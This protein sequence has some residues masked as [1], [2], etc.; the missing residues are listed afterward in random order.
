[1]FTDDDEQRREAL[2]E[3]LDENERAA[4]AEVVAAEDLIS[5]NHVRRVR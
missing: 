4:L 2:A 5:I 3:P 1:M